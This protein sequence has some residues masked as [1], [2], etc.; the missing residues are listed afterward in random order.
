[1]SRPKAAQAR[2]SW[3]LQSSL[4]LG[5]LPT[6]AGCA[7]LHA[8][9]VVC[10]WG[11]ASLAEAVEL[12]VSELVTNAFFASTYPDGRP[13]YRHGAG[14]PHV[15]L[16]L[17]SDLVRVLIQVWDQNPHPPIQEVAAPDEESGRGLMLVEALS[18]RWNWDVPPEWGGK[19]VWAELKVA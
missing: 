17:S 8:R 3:P 10:E 15:H 12:V 16:M 14:L 6:T 1:M 5:V 2:V 9:K 19:V 18:E 4:M 11:L 13:R 7:R